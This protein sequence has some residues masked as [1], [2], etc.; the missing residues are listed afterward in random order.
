MI[1]PG[2]SIIVKANQKE[3]K[4]LFIDTKIDITHLSTF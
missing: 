4:S 3:L 1:Q 2:V